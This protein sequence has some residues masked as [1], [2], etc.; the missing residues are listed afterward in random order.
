MYDDYQSNF[1]FIGNFG[2]WSRDLLDLD[3]K[4]WSSLNQEAEPWSRNSSMF[5]VFRSSLSDLEWPKVIDHSSISSANTTGEWKRYE[6]LDGRSIYVS[7]CFQRFYVQPQYVNMVVRKPTSEPVV[8]WDGFSAEHDTTAVSS[9][10]SADSPVKPPC[11]RGIMD[12]DILPKPDLS[13]I[14]S[15]SPDGQ[16]FAGTTSAMLHRHVM[17]VMTNNL[18]G[19]SISGCIFCH[20]YSIVV[21]SDLG[22]LFTDTIESTGRA[23][24]ALHS[25]TAII[26]ATFYDTLLKVFNVTEDTTM[27]V[28]TSVRTPGPCS[29]HRCSGF[30][31]VTT[32]LGV[33]MVIVATI[34]SL[35]IGQVR[36]SRC[37]NTWHV[38]SQ[39]M[40]EELVDVLEQAN[41]A[42]DKSITKML[43]RGGKNDF[44]RLGLMGDCTGIQVMKHAGNNRTPGGDKGSSTF[45]TR[46]KQRWFKGNEVCA[47]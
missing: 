21:P 39:L 45:G 12:M 28:T 22:L 44:V 30:I 2:P 37:S 36:Y 24:A 23:A 3:T 8:V 1:C 20:D 10:V 40:S 7:L 17:T 15:K 6:I 4:E 38:V 42:G 9:F 13:V 14:D 47:T 18:Y 5:L 19:G 26:S 43:Q 11:D 46:L 41:N 31:S 32:L 27:A 25:F 33:H 29:D 35:Y 16:T 34:T